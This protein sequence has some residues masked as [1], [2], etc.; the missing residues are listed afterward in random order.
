M[1][2]VSLTLKKHIEQD[3]NLV[4]NRFIINFRKQHNWTDFKI[5]YK[6]G[7]I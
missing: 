5:P 7:E 4:L 1:S 3:S 6:T 2:R